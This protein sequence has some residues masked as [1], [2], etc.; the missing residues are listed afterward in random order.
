MRFVFNLYNVGLGN[1]GGSRTLIR[2]GEALSQ[3]GVDVV[4]FSNIKSRYSWHNPSGIKYV[5]S[6]KPP[7][8][9]VV[10]ATGYKS[11]NSTLKTR[12]KKKIYYIRGFEKWQ[13]DKD[14]LL[15]SYR[16]LHCFVNSEWLQQ[17]L[18][19][20]GVHS[21]VIYP[22][23]DLGFFENQN[24][25][26]ENIFGSL[27][28]K[29]HKTKRH[30]D[31]QAVANKTGYKLELLNQDIKN[32]TPSGMQ[33]WY[34]KLKIWF[35]PTELEGLHNPP[36]ESSLCGCSLVCTDHPKS[37]MGDYAIHEK[38]ALVYEAR[39]I[40]K[41]SSYVNSLM[42]NEALREKLNNNMVELLKNK[43]GTRKRNMSRFLESIGEIKR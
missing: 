20:C 12:A 4:M 41:A 11:V 18:S 5:Y 17:W 29:K 33:Q 43:I 19:R 26:R 31:A 21:E 6:E 22:G 7:K 32:A 8:C 30:I 38:T 13:A 35:A 10:C 25:D 37:G 34:N 2:C 39:N 24:N 40:K 42:D 16:K 36:I 23:L 9:D 14:K 3:L 28:H 27:F 1:N 15:E